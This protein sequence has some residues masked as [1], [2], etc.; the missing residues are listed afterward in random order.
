MRRTGHAT[1]RTRRRA[2]LFGFNGNNLTLKGMHGSLGQGRC[3]N[4]AN[5]S[6]FGQF[7]YCNAPAFFRAANRAIQAGLLK[8]PALGTA[9]DGQT[10]PTVRDFGVVDMDQSDNVTT[11]YLVTADGLTAQ[12]TAANVNNLQNAQTQA[13]GSDNRLLAV[14]LD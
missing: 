5:G 14:A 11:T 9:T 4:G 13:N 10:C 8:P 6:I 2:L 3:V 7:A 12:M 1:R